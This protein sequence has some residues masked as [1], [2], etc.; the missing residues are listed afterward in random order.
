M[1]INKLI[2]I[3]IKKADKVALVVIALFFIFMLYFSWL[4]W[5]HP[6]IDCGRE[7]YVP[8]QISNG[9]MLYKDLAYFYGPFAPYFIAII[10][11]LLGAS[12]NTLY[13][14]GITTNILLC[15]VLY[16]LS[17]QL[18][19]PFISCLT[20]LFYMQIGIIAPNLGSY[21]GFIYPYSFAALFGLLFI[22]IQLSLIVTYYKY[23]TSNTIIYLIGLFSALAISCKQDYA[24]SSLL[25]LILFSIYLI[26]TKINNKYLYIYWGITLMIP[27]FAYGIFFLYAPIDLLITK[28]LFPINNITSEHSHTIIVSF[29][30]FYHLTVS[31][32]NF[33]ITIF[34][35]AAITI[36][37]YIIWLLYIKI[38]EF[39]SLNLK[40]KVSPA[41]FYTILTVPTFYLLF[42]L[43]SFTIKNI[44]FIETG[45]NHI[46][47]ICW[48]PLFITITLFYYAHKIKI[49]KESL[50]QTDLLYCLLGIASI[51]ISIR[52][53][54]YCFSSYLAMPIIIVIFYLFTVKL[55]GFCEN[56]KFI[57]K[58]ALNYSTISVII[59]FIMLFCI[60][61]LL[62]F[63]YQC[64]SVKSPNG[65]FN[66]FKAY[67]NG[68]N[69]A[70]DFIEKNLKKD[71]LIT[72]F[73]EETLINFLT[74]HPSPTRMY[75]YM[76]INNTVMSD[77]EFNY[78]I[79]QLINSRY[80]FISNF[81]YF[82]S[83]KYYFGLNYHK[84][85]GRWINE[86]Y[87]A[88]AM[89]GKY[90]LI[91]NKPVE[92]YGFIIFKRKE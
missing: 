68:Y 18:L 7:A 74:R 72:V 69:S 71:D 15:L 92:N 62:T 43:L 73:P 52:G 89:A 56:I 13:F 50:S 41:I 83:E 14:I 84:K 10:F 9:K 58:N 64:Y 49:K 20:L 30:S 4:K 54:A 25:L 28:Y 27:V 34:I 21:E 85:L 51:V 32:K 16:F 23:N 8:W 88:I 36:L 55:P 57:N 67:A 37:F 35:I 81:P 91:Y 63:S 26:K 87:V 29:F 12:L 17:R 77:I 5:L 47:Y 48:Y 66:T 70:L 65:S 86:H 24:L 44:S 82:L 31:A 61:D 6:I 46:H 80:I 59:I 75:Q 39:Y 40:E 76:D 60:K 33:L 11:K 2:S 19:S 3:K 79:E 90:E 45:V 78:N 38:I 53:F 42:E 1:Y 22:L